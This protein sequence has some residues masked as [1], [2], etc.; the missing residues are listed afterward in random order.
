MNGC[1]SYQYNRSYV[2]SAAD[3]TPLAAH[4]AVQREDYL[5]VAQYNTPLLKM[6]FLWQKDLTTKIKKYV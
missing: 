1:D 2:V 3:Q 5:Q 6:T 4:L